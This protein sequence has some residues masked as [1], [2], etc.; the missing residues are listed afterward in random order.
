M[1]Q[2]KKLTRT[3]MLSKPVSRIQQF[4]NRSPYSYQ[5]GSSHLANRATARGI[6]NEYKSGKLT[7]VDGYFKLNNKD[8]MA[9]T[10]KNNK[11]ATAKAAAVTK[12]AKQILDEQ[13]RD[14]KK[15]FKSN[16]KGLYNAKTGAKRASEEY[17]K[18]YGDT[19][20]KRWEN[21]IKKAKGN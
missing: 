1:T 3:E 19:P 5:E 18:K 13:K 7:I 12:R 21:A 9:K 15:I 2:E 11:K 14:W 6:F 20:Q 4:A 16:V 8:N 10:K 17:R